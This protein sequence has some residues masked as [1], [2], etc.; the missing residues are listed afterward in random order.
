MRHAP[1][2]KAIVEGKTKVFS[3]Y[4]ILVAD[5]TKDLRWQSDQK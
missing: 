2:R 3:H 4:S 5:V 1:H